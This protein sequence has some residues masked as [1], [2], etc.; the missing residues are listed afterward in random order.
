MF[1]LFL[2]QTKSR[3]TYLS[4]IS[5]YYQKINEH[6]KTLQ[7]KE[8]CLKSS[9]VLP[10]NCIRP[11]IKLLLKLRNPLQHLLCSYCNPK[12]D[13]AYLSR[14][15]YYYKQINK[16]KKKYNR[17]Q[18]TLT[19]HMCLLLIAFSQPLSFSLNWSSSFNVLCICMEDMQSDIN[20]K[21]WCYDIHILVHPFLV[22]SVIIAN[23]PI[24][25]MIDLY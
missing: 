12:L 18:H 1:S 2:L 13:L 21:I 9:Y 6:E 3:F 7:E 20:D 11:T 17:W 5:Y 22:L 23:N 15:S 10:I 16:H 24:V 19:H 4:K 8:T 25:Y 14:I